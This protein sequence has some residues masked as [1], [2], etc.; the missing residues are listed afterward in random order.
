MK[1]AILAGALSCALATSAC[2]S[3]DR[4][5][6]AS[7]GTQIGITAAGAAIGSAATGG[8]VSADVSAAVKAVQVYA[9]KNCVA[10]PTTASVFSILSAAAGTLSLTEI[11]NIACGAVNVASAYAADDPNS[12]P[13][14]QRRPPPGTVI[15]RQIT[16]NGQTVTV[17]AVVPARNP[18]K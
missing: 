11:K 1:L 8:S 4:S 2:T 12:P 15:E 9:V 13:S 5:A 10:V 7:T 3:T 14:V 16:V 6:L 18:K 17:Q